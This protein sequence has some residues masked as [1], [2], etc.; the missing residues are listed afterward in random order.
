MP[1][2]SDFMTD[3]HR[4]CDNMF[5]AAEQAANQEHWEEA[6]RATKE[7]LNEMELHFLMEENVL[8]P[9]LEEKTGM[10]MG[11][12]QVMRLEHGQMRELFEQMQ[13]ALDS[14]SKDDFLG[15]SET[16]LITMQ[17]HNMKEEGI[18]YPMSDE[19]FSEKSADVLEQMKRAS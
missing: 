13:Q 18:V 4:H 1:S 8:F 12:T 10:T 11:P 17:Q 14:K 5:A 2:I 3:N 15:A 7:F 6:K 16:L 19:Q 9:A